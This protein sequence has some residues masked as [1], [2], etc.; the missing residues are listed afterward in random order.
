MFR[1]MYYIDDLKQLNNY[2]YKDREFSD[3]CKRQLKEISLKIY[4][5]FYEF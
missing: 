2:E 3:E 4:N 1:N 5:S